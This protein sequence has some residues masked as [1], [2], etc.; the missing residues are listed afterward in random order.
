M[1]ICCFPN[2]AYLSETSRMI[3]VYKQ[4]SVKREKAIIATHGWTYEF[5]LKEE[6]IPFEYVVPIMSG[7][8]SQ[9]FV[10]ANRGE[11][12][13]QSFYKIDELREHVQSEI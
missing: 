11:R 7:E 12:G 3:S 9:E 4:L 10:V 8:R 5:F 2:C 1:T 13:L 6:R